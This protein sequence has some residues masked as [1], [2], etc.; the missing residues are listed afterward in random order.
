MKTEQEKSWAP[1]R[2]AANYATCYVSERIINVLSADH[3]PSTSLGSKSAATS[4]H[5][6]RHNHV[7]AAQLLI[8]THRFNTKGVM[9]SSC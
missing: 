8:P 4:A 1:Q 7:M 3:S 5:V 9:P 6:T 2:M